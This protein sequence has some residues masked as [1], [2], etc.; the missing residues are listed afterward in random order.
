MT[1]Q[2]AAPDELAHVLAPP[3]PGGR[4]AP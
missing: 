2:T 3:A 1:L 4:S